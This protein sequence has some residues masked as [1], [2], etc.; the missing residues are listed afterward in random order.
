MFERS[1]WAVHSALIKKNILSGFLYDAQYLWLA[2][3]TKIVTWYSTPPKANL[4]LACHGGGNIYSWQTGVMVH[5]STGNRHQ[6]DSSVTLGWQYHSREESPQSTRQE[7]VLFMPSN[8]KWPCG[9]WLLFL[10]YMWTHMETSS[11]K[12]PL[13][14][15]DATEQR[16]VYIA[17]Q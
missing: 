11:K 12:R 4:W 13:K 14:H 16:H 8:S 9:C 6:C 2:H 5:W 15:W 3:N 17:A 10:Q 1:R 7:P